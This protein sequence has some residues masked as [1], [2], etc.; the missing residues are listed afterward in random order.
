MPIELR[1]Y[2]T[3]APKMPGNADALP[4]APGE[5]VSALVDRL[6]IPRDEVRI[7]FVNGV[8]ADMDRALA[9]GDRVGIFPPVGG[10]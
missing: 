10:G 9:D 1:C 3:L 2:A 4:I 7:V 5:T 8:S 6:G